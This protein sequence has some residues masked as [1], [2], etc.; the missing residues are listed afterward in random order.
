MENFKYGELTIPIPGIGWVDAKLVDYRKLNPLQDSNNET[1]NI[2]LGP[3]EEE[4]TPG[5][6]Y[7][8]LKSL[9]FQS[10]GKYQWTHPVLGDEILWFDIE[11]D[12]LMSIISRVFK[13]GYKRA[14]HET[15]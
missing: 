10:I 4:L 13:A 7:W 2:A 12:H 3:T 6:K 14:K 8:I 15:K 11:N 5:N 1:L 9:L